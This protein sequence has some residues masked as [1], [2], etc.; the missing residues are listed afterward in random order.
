MADSLAEGDLKMFLLACQLLD[1]LR[2]LTLCLG[3]CHFNVNGLRN[4]VDRIKERSPAWSK[5]ETEVVKDNLELQDHST[6]HARQCA[7]IF[8]QRRA[9]ELG[10]NENDTSLCMSGHGGVS[11]FRVVVDLSQ[12]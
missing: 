9:I 12:A 11:H 5:L 2:T 1:G 8:V 3:A 10:R 4:H 7:K 6:I